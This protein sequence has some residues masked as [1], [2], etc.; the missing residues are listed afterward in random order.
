MLRRA[1]NHLCTCHLFVFFVSI[2]PG[3]LLFYEQSVSA[4]GCLKKTGTFDLD[5]PFGKPGI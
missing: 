1:L 5:F 3:L 2:V 4:H